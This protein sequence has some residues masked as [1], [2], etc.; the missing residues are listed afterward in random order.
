[1]K[2]IIFLGT[3]IL[4]NA[5]TTINLSNTNSKF[6]SSCQ[7]YFNMLDKNVAQSS[8]SSAELAQ[9]KRNKNKLSQLPEKEQNKICLLRMASI[10]QYRN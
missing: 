2:K 1:M 10:Q 4:L 5:C 9:F 7:S 3:V 6:P 8:L